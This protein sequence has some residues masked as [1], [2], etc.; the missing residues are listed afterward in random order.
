MTKDHS[1]VEKY[2]Q[3]IG[4]EFKWEK[5]GSLAFGYKRPAFTTFPV[6]GTYKE[7]LMK[8]IGEQNLSNFE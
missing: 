3:G 8:P 2:L 5:D 1:D 4:A 6:T 7:C